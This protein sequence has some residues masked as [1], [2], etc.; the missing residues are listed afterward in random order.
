MTFL[1]HILYSIPQAF[2]RL[3]W[4]QR[5]YVMHY[6]PSL[7][8]I[9]FLNEGIRNRTLKLT[10]EIV[11]LTWARSKHHICQSQNFQIFIYFYQSFELCLE[12][13]KTLEQLL[14]HGVPCYL[15]AFQN[16]CSSQSFCIVYTAVI[17]P[18]LSYSL[19]YK[20]KVSSFPSS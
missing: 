13:S 16:F 17:H 7:Y 11:R 15:S 2:R 20:N 14:Q 3:M 9:Y 8:Q 4:P 18:K 12:I 19:C 5:F 1:K 10:Q 6:F